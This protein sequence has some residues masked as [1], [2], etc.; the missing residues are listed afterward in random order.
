MRATGTD[1]TA[2]LL[3]VLVAGG[4]VLGAVVHLRLAPGYQL[5]Q[6]AGIGQGNLFRIQAAV[7][8]ISAGYL[9]MRGTGPA[10]L[11]AAAVG[12]GGLVAVV[13]Y[14]YVDVPALGPLPRMYEPVWFFEK[15]LSAAAQGLAGVLALV[16][17]ALQRPSAPGDGHGGTGF[18]R[19]RLSRPRG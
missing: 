2:L 19:V 3:R 6:P 5:A 9:L 4:L 16:G 14:R 17:A 8:L 15:T 12:L 7:A 18:V 1:A 13:L 10:F 11:L